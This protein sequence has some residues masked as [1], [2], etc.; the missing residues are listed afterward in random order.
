MKCM[1]LSKNSFS[2]IQRLRQSG[3][4]LATFLPQKNDIC[5]SYHVF[6]LLP[7][8]QNSKALILGIQMSMKDFIS[9]ECQAV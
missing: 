9:H 4:L 3:R 8:L 6:S 2:L 5:S 1:C 7:C